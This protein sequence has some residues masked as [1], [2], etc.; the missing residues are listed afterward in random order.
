MANECLTTKRQTAYEFELKKAK[1]HTHIDIKKLWVAI[2][3]DLKN[4]VKNQ[5]IAY[6]FHLSLA[7]LLV[8]TVLQLFPMANKCPFC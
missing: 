7:E 1:N 2:L 4:K 8:K 3:K 5:D 6:R